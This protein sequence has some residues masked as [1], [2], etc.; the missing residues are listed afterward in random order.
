MFLK[1]YDLQKEK[2]FGPLPLNLKHPLKGTAFIKVSV[3]KAALG[4]T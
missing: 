3:I 2:G 1:E 4:V